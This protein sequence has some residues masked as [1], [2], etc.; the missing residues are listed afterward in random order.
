MLTCSDFRLWQ[1]ISAMSSLPSPT[2]L[3]TEP[4]EHENEDRAEYPYITGFYLFDCFFFFHYYY[5]GLSMIEKKENL[6]LLMDPSG[7]WPPGQLYVCWMYN[8]CACPWGHRG[9]WELAVWG[10]GAAPFAAVGPHAGLCTASFCLRRSAAEKYSQKENNLFTL[11]HWHVKVI[12]Y[13]W[14]N[15]TISWRSRILEVTLRNKEFFMHSKPDPWRVVVFAVSCRRCFVSH[16]QVL[17]LLLFPTIAVFNK[18]LREIQNCTGVI[19]N[20][21]KG[22][23]QS[24]RNTTAGKSAP[25]FLMANRTIFSHETLKTAFL[26]EDLARSPI[27]QNILHN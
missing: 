21:P 24:Y 5:F 14:E 25:C 6:K 23:T 9:W 16:E 7:D 1:E 2:Q 19:P 22:V 3:K 17:T 20:K 26:K 18:A 13:L 8:P 12:A 15:W 4:C 27:T 10:G 11:P